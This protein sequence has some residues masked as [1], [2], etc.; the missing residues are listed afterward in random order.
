MNAAILWWSLS[1]S[2][3]GSQGISIN[4]LRSQKIATSVTQALQGSLFFW[5][6]AGARASWPLSP[7]TTPAFTAEH[8]KKVS[9]NTHTEHV[10]ISAPH[11]QKQ[12]QR[13]VGISNDIYFQ[14]RFSSLTDSLGKIFADGPS[15]CA[16]LPSPSLTNTPSICC[17]IV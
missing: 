16:V 4:S 11:R 9:R 17:T 6:S 14:L 1:Y 15:I 13:K 7:C 2:T 3:R 8:N 5:G 10:A 12:G